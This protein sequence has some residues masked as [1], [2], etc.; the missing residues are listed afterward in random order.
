MYQ[1]DAIK[2]V[3]NKWTKL[4]Q[5]WWQLARAEQKEV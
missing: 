2:Y 3:M 4:N 5:T 1:S